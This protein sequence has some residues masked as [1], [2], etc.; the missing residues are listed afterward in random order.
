MEKIEVVIRNPFEGL[1]DRATKEMTLTSVDM[2]GRQVCVRLEPT[3]TRALFD[4]FVAM[5]DM[6]LQP[7][8]ESAPVAKQ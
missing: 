4:I 5:A 2:S 6:G 3:A 1:Y 7:G 8:E